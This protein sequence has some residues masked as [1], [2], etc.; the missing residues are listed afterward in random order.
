[1]AAQLIDN[2]HAARVGCTMPVDP[3]RSQS[4]QQQQACGNIFSNSIMLWALS[5]LAQPLADART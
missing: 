5:L 1:M 3:Q 4:Q 2:V